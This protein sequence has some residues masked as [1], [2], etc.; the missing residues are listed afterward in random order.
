MKIFKL[1]IILSLLT[2]FAFPQN[3]N[4]KNVFTFSHPVKYGNADSK[5]HS[6]FHSPFS[7]D[8]IKV[9]AVMVQFQE[10]NDPRTT[11]NGL[12]DLSNKY[13]DPVLQK[14]TVIDSP[15]YDS[16]YFADHLEFLKN[17]YYKSSKGKVIINYKLYG[18]IITLPQV[19]S[20][21]SP[22]SNE[23]NQKLGQLFL[24][25]WSRADSVL[26]LSSYDTSNTAFVIFHAGVGR[27]LNLVSIFGYDPFPYDVPSI[28]L[29]YKNLQ[30]L[31]INGF[32]SHT[33][34]L[35]KNSL[36]I[37]STEIRELSLISETAL[38]KFGINGI[39]VA[40]IGSY[41]GLPDLFN[42]ATGNT[43]IGRFGLMDGQAILSYNGI[44]PP[45]PSA[46]E[47][48]YLG[49]VTPVVVSSGDA[50]INLKTS[51][52]N[53][54]I[55]TSIIKVLIN[56]KEYFLIE[57]RNRNY[58]NTGQKV[59]THNRAFHDSLLFTK[60]S[61]S[62]I[63]YN[64]DAVS[65][66][67]TNV[68][69]LDWSMPGDIS[70]T[71][72][73]S[74]GILIWHID[75]N[76]I[77]ANIGTNSINND[78]NHRGVKLMEA[79]GSQDIGVTYHTPFGD[80]IS[81]GY[82]VDFWYNGNHYVPANI[83]RNEF[84]PTSIPNSLSYSLANNNIYITD[85]DPI[86]ATMKFRVRIG[87]DIIR[88]LAGFPKYIGGTNLFNN[89]QPIAFDLD[90]DGR[91]EFFINNSTNLYGFKTDGTPISGDPSNV[92]V[93]NFGRTPAVTA[94]SSA[95]GNSKRLVLTSGNNI[96]GFYK[97]VNNI[98]TDSTFDNLISSPAFPL[99]YDS[100]K[101]V[102]GFS[103][104]WIEE[105]KLDGSVNYID[106]ASR[107]S[108][109]YLSKID[110]NRYS[111]RTGNTKYIITGN[112]K[113]QNSIDSLELVYANSSFILDGNLLNI[114]YKITHANNPILADV[115]KDGRQEIIFSADEGLFVINSSGVL[116]ENFPVNFNKTVSP[117]IAVADV[118]NDGIMD[119]IF[120]TSDGDLYAFG[121]NGK[122]VSGYPIKTGP[123]SFSTPAF[124]N[125][126][127]TLGIITFG[128]DK[129][130]Y[131]YK[132]NVRY[133]ENKI[134]WKNFLKDKYLSNNNYKILTSTVNYSEKLPSDKVYNWPNPV[135]D[136]K[137]FIRYYIN[138]IAS[139]VT[140]KILDLSGEL[141]TTLN[142]TAFSN[143]DNE[144]T[145]DVSTVQSGIYYGVV[146]AQI[147]GSKERK[148]IKIAVVK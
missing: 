83:Y 82:F 142:G 45:E 88:P 90:G 39:L 77:D 60:D 67:V 141:V 126:N 6:R 118:N 113:N 13:Y 104:G 49:W 57:N 14:D 63:N 66:N 143:A 101:I 96:L 42:T 95:L 53:N 138:G 85:F 62:F 21:Y 46:W 136:S 2:G 33:G 54:G 3:K 105:R 43:A 24:D 116:L 8:T 26:D 59:Y 4:G 1:F 32:T 29:G 20:A 148:I 47:K 97:T 125:L 10:D 139:T 102:L 108:V 123:N 75:E 50:F 80:V 87:S 52:S 41:L 99:V 69:Y 92:L 94:Y 140:V 76:V 30:E 100:S 120:T 79:K 130:L 9:V 137:T 128:G 73:Y 132:T 106:S 103:N 19:M 5:K 114:N 25:T 119:I 78:L 124:A 71:S 74:G 133:D 107:N 98:I 68:K 110:Q 65:G 93:Y 58:D 37:P 147:D 112:L 84:T 15:P 56:A 81:D 131:A 36:I 89:T 61:P 117:G 40:N 146:E 38:L 35:I 115:N 129:Y 48:I 44:F 11:G 27:D 70:D 64:I 23:T 31:N 34:F 72:N 22:Q 55:D 145:W 18:K 16:S 28:Y 144:I 111:Y 51:S 127:D 12:L 7:S 134:L 135:Y 86:A 122:V 91:D 121:I 17:Y 109:S